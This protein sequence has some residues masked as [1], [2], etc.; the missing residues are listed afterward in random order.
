MCRVCHTWACWPFAG[1]AMV[2]SNR[3]A[4]RGSTLAAVATNPPRNLPTLPSSTSIW[5][6]PVVLLEHDHQWVQPGR[7]SSSHLIRIPKTSSAQPEQPTVGKI[8][9]LATWD[10]QCAS[11]T[12][13]SVMLTSGPRHG[14]IEIRGEAFAVG[15][16]CLA[17]S[18]KS[19]AKRSSTCLT[20]PH[21]NESVVVR[22]FVGKGRG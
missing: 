21:W 8:A 20:H 22:V 19:P 18:R 10:K 1:N 6:V 13:T 17:S 11:A 12:L 5:L 7:C 4:T 14:R 16:T 3:I 15:G 2:V 9:Q